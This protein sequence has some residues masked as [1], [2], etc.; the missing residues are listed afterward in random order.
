MNQIEFNPKKDAFVV[1]MNNYKQCKRF[2]GL[3]EE[4]LKEPDTCPNRDIIWKY[5]FEMVFQ[6]DRLSLEIYYVY[7][8]SSFEEYVDDHRNNVHY[9]DMDDSDGVEQFLRIVHREVHKPQRLY[10]PLKIVLE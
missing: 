3:V 8:G 10:A 9:L 6:Y 5:P 2:G 1:S 4:I 7:Y